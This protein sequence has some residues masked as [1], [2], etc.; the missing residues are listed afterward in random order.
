[1]AAS[2]LFSFYLENFANYNAAY[3]TLGAFTGLM[4]WVWISV[5]IQIVGVE[6]S[7]ELEHQTVRDSTTGSPKS[8]GARGA[9]VADTIGE[10]AD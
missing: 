7:A 3:G 5:I 6:L 8:M 10:A 9:F 2:I 4:V 1:M